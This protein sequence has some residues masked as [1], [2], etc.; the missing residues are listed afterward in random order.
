MSV[1]SVSSSSDSLYDI[2]QNLKSQQSSSS[3]SETSQS[4]RKKPGELMTEA[5]KEQG[6][7]DD[8]ISEIQSKIK[9]LFQQNKQNA[10]DGSTSSTSPTDMQDSINSILQQYG[11]DTDQVDQYM[12]ANRPQGGMGGGM[13]PM[14][15]NMSTTGGVD[16]YA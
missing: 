6:V 14:G 15:V 12:Q 13:P 11:V 1:S 3:T 4:S 7:D 16:M 8:T 5:L 9:D 2:L 10:Q